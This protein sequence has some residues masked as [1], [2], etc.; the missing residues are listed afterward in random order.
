MSRL[1]AKARGLALSGLLLLA[2]SPR[3][4][5]GY[6]LTRT[7]ADKRNAAN[8]TLGTCPQLDRFNIAVAGNID[9][10]WNT[11]LGSNIRTNPNPAPGETPLTEMRALILRAYDA[12]AN[13]SGAALR[14]NAFGAL[15]ENNSFG[16]N[17]ADGLNTIC[18]S[19]SDPL[20]SPGVLAFTNTITSDIL[21]E[22]F[23]GQQATFIGEILDADVLVNPTATFATPNALAGNPPAF[24]LESVL[25]H[26]LG[27]TLGFS[28]SGVWR[29]MMYPFA[30]V[31]GSFTGDR[32]TP[33]A[34]D[35]PLSDDDRTGLRVLY[36][37]AADAVHVGSIAGRVVPASLLT[38]AGQSGVTGIFGAQVVAVDDATGAVAGAVL[39]G[40]SC[41]GAGPVQFDGSYTIERLPVNRSYRIYA[42]PMDGPVS[43]AHFSAAINS[44]CRPYQ[45]DVNYPAQFSCTV[46]PANTIFVTRTKP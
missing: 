7:V 41:S 25:I 16:C 36:P 28:H 43:P 27:H 15:G 44:I 26:E 9:R 40:W 35:A 22:Q 42:E 30:P 38:L 39:S 29:A 20:F 2:A 6:A 21:G 11:S 5:Q 19:Q 23:A 1:R 13:V 37:D 17:S 34:P 8:S 33:I 14:P 32:P 18:F 45:A 31:P 12:W 24:D 46:P 4:A 10:R 3:P